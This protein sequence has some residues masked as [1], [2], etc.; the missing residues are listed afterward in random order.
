MHRPETNGSGARGKHQPVPFPGRR[1]PRADGPRDDARVQSE[2]LSYI[3]WVY[4]THLNSY[5]ALLLG[6]V[7][8]GPC[9]FGTR[10]SPRSPRTWLW[11]PGAETLPRFS[12]AGHPGTLFTSALVFHVPNSL[13]QKPRWVALNSSTVSSRN[14][15]QRFQIPSRGR[16]QQRFHP[17]SPL[18]VHFSPAFARECART[19]FRGESGGE[20]NVKR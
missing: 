20:M 10:G 5:F 15:Q 11:A 7:C 14:P 6:H 8:V 12:A 19:I 3:A 9:P 1:R 16:L 18:H 2:R 13:F 4:C 17:R